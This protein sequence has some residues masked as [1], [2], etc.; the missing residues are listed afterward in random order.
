LEARN[1]V[2]K[3]KENLPKLEKTFLDQIVEYINSAIDKF[4]SSYEEIDFNIEFDLVLESERGFNLIKLVNE[5]NCKVNLNMNL[6]TMIDDLETQT[7]A[8]AN[9]NQSF[10][11]KS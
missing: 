3:I 9:L 1:T 10:A 2:D 11:T 8:L 6:K 4:N 5:P 7:Q